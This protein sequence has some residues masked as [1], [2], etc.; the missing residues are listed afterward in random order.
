MWMV[1][2]VAMLFAVAGRWVIQAAGGPAVATIV[3]Q[4]KHWGVP[5]NL[6]YRKRRARRPLRHPERSREAA[7]S[8][9]PPLAR[10]RTS[11]GSLGSLRSPGMTK[12]GASFAR[13]EGGGL[14]RV[15]P[16][17]MK[18][19]SR[20]VWDGKRRFPSRDAARLPGKAAGEDDPTT[21][22]DG[23]K[24]GGR[25]SKRLPPV[26]NTSR[27]VEPRG[28][29]SLPKISLY[30]AGVII[31]VLCD[32]TIFQTALSKPPAQVS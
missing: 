28:Y 23:K 16:G 31:L 22:S 19:T 26:V 3:T 12:K 17:M 5:D 27:L 25:R 7:E 20:S 32:G 4:R 18:A 8:K 30:S 1:S 24:K 9:D 11:G 14:L 6:G 21:S 15:L 13:N 10:Q 29:Q 2:W